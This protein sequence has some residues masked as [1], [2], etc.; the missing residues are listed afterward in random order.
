MI[1][2]DANVLLYAVNEQAEHHERSRRWLDSALSGQET[3][4][5]AWIAILAFVRLKDQ[6]RALS[7]SIGDVAGTSRRP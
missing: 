6:A 4:G 5:F 7:A 3:V 2:V 1:L